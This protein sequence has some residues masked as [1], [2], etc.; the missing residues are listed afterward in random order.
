MWSRWSPRKQETK[1]KQRALWYYNAR[2]VT[3]HTADF[4][5]YLYYKQV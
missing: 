4:A 1:K 5:L 3:N 2:S